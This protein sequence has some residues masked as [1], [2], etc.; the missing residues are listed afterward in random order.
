MHICFV[1]EG[2]PT[3]DDPF[4]TFIR[5]LVASMVLKGTKCSVIAP[6]SL[7]RAYKHKLPVRPKYWKDYVSEEK[8]IDV[9][10]PYYFTL[11]SKVPSVQWKSMIKAAKSAYKKIKTPVDALYG[12]F[13]HMGVLASKIKCDLPIFVA[14]GESKIEVFD[15]FSSE[16]INV[17]K[18]RLKG[19]V[20]VGTKSF[21][22]AKELKLHDDK[23][24]II[25]P[26]G[27][28][29]KEFHPVD[30]DKCREKLGWDTEK[31]IVC[32]VGSFNSRKGIDRLSQ[33]INKSDEEIY[34]C[35]IG[36][37]DLK[38]D[39]DNILFCGK[40]PHNEILT[41]ICACDVFV[42]PTNNEGCCNAIVEALACGMPVISSNQL[43]NAD[44]LND[45]CSIRIDPM[46]VDALKNAIE[47]IKNDKDLRNNLT[48]GALLKS[49]PLA[50]DKRAE[51]ILTFIGES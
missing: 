6:Q 14:C 50:I 9:Y 33:A 22:E 5:E 45:N 23:P 27:Y 12:H 25:A 26:N 2:Y 29:P 7:T 44:I 1:V 4:M 32:F 35:F 48:K 51:K 10:Q 3:K 38:P 47:N 17:L 36:S 13:W 24:Y 19:I 43:F 8:Y 41:Y 49:E 30:K 34:S 40:V 37:G 28:N 46:D 20:Y 31:F 21:E 39:C 18:K 16:E 42:L 11:S 15:D